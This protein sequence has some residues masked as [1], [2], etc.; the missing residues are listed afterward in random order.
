MAMSAPPIANRRI[1]V[2]D[3]NRAIH[4]DFRNIL[5]PELAQGF[6]FCRPLPPDQSRELL[7]D[8]TERASFTETLRMRIA[9]ARRLTV[10]DEQIPKPGDA[11]WAAR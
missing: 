3:D 10:V 2:I 5:G 4:E 11:K 1:L 6:Y 8:L 9:P 7:V